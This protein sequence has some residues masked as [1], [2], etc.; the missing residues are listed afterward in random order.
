MSWQLLVPIAEQLVKAGIEYYNSGETTQGE[1][2]AKEEESK[3]TPGF[4][5]LASLKTTSG[6]ELDEAELKSQITTALELV[7]GLDVV[8]L[9][10]K[11]DGS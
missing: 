9:E 8:S 11:Q 2:T 7:D 4:V 1:T 10:V 6:S 3:A 5:L